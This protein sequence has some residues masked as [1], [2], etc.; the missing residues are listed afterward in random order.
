LKTLLDELHRSASEAAST[1]DPNSESVLS[2]RP[3]PLL[4]ID[5]LCCPA[6]DGPGKQKAIEKLRL[7]YRMSH[8]VLVLDAS[9]F[10]ITSKDMHIGE[11]ALRAYTSPWMGRL[12]TLQGEPCSK[13][14]SGNH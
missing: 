7:V 4:W 14:R 1:A 9:L 3:A 8:K 10:S 13:F 11:I 5:T 12:W 6:I 2:L